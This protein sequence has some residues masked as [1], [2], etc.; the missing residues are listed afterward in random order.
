[1]LKLSAVYNEACVN[2][3]VRIHCVIRQ[4]IDSCPRVHSCP[5][6][7]NIKIYKRQATRNHKQ[8]TMF[9]HLPSVKTKL[10]NYKP[11]PV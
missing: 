11:R 7:W 10:R 9:S 3:S 5:S 6:V 8:A 2:I 1:M 4:A